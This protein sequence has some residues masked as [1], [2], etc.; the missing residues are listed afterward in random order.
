MKVLQSFAILENMYPK[1]L[2]HHYWSVCM[3]R[4]PN[5]AHV[6]GND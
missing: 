5:G 1:I 3:A 4:E 6:G 2:F